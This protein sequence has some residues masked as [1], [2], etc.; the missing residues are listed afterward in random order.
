MV[1]RWASAGKAVW[2]ADNR[3]ACRKERGMVLLC[4]E[5]ILHMEV[6]LGCQPPQFIEENTSPSLPLKAS[7]L[8]ALKDTELLAPLSKKAAGTKSVAKSLAP[9]S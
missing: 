4:V 5:E 6:L 3:Q 9:R 8:A 7:K 1:K 2:G